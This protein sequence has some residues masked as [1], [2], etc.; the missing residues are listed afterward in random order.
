MVALKIMLKLMSLNQAAP[1]LV[2]YKQHH[3]ASRSL[4]KELSKELDVP[5]FEI[6]DVSTLKKV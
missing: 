5:I 2:S 4:I 1:I 6:D 3:S